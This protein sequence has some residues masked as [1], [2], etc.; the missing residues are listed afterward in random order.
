M[1]VILLSAERSYAGHGA[2]NQM[3]TVF[4]NAG[5]KSLAMV[6][7]YRHEITA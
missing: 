5:R 2:E 4:V 6:M 7:D 3:G 1:G